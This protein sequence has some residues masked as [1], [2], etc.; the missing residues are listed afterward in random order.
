[1]RARGLAVKKKIV[2][3]IEFFKNVIGV[4]FVL[5]RNLKGVFKLK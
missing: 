1:M 2:K 3:L 5:N 4:T